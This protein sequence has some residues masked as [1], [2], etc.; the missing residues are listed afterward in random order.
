MGSR[1]E[2]RID[3]NLVSEPMKYC[4][5]HTTIIE[6]FMTIQYIEVF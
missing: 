3:R 4:L 2:M 5:E 1:D 6:S